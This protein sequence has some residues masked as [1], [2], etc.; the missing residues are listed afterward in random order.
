MAVTV[1][2]D[3]T[4]TWVAAAT[5]G[6]C[7]MSSEDQGFRFAMTAGSAPAGTLVGHGVP[8]RTTV[9]VEVPASTTLYVRGTGPLHVTAEAA[10]T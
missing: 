1:K 2:L 9:E 5:A 4:D 8:P 3:L 7:V 10:P 6:S